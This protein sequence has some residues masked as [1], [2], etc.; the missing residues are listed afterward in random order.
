MH[1]AYRDRQEPQ[2]RN[3]PEPEYGLVEIEQIFRTRGIVGVYPCGLNWR[4]SPDHF[5]GGLV[6][7]QV[8]E[9]RGRVAV[10]AVGKAP[11]ERRKARVGI[12]RSE[13]HI[14]EAGVVPNALGAE[15]VD[16]AQRVRVSTWVD[17]RERV[18]AL[19]DFPGLVDRAG[20]AQ[21]DERGQP[22]AATARC[23]HAGCR[24]GQAVK[25]AS[26]RQ[27]RD[28]RDAPAGPALRQPNHFS[29]GPAA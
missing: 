3:R 2:A 28:R 8:G 11:S 20:A 5:G 18:A 17:G 19:S 13:Q 6:L 12:A 10:A 27:R 7:E 14:A 21:Q 1:R 15:A 24:P 23:S 26:R 25:H 4:L 16:F 29:I 9:V 22:E